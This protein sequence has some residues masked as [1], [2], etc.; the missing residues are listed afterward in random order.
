MQ[1]TLTAV[2]DSTIP[3]TQEVLFFLGEGVRARRVTGGN[4]MWIPGMYSELEDPEQIFIFPL[5]S[6][7]SSP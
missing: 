7:W 2:V 5:M 3:G 4:V 1:T 6:S